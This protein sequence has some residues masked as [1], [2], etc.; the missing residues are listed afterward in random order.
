MGNKNEKVVEAERK[1]E[2]G[3]KDKKMR[4][5]NIEMKR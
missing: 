4:A 3:K 5:E 2:E 1:R